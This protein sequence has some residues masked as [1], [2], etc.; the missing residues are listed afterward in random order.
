MVMTYQGMPFPAAWT[1]DSAGKTAEYAAILRKDV[2]TP[3]GVEAPFAE[4]E[5]QRHAWTFSISKQDLAKALGAVRVTE[6]DLYQDAKS[7]KVYGAKFKEGNETRQL[8]FAK[9]QTSLGQSLLKSNDF[10]I[11]VAGD[12]ITFKGFGEGNGVGLC[13]FS[14]NAMADKGE[15]AP[16]ILNGF[17]PKTKLEK[18]RSLD[19]LN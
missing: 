2:A 18:I 19:E 17:F 4:H 11:Q 13:L 10:T 9:L 3:P 1:K 16:K 7:K 14:A 6:F 12:K 5:R 8:D 15:R